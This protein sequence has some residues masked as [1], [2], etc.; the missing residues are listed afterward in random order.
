MNKKRSA[1]S[2]RPPKEI[3]NDVP[4]VVHSSTPHKLVTRNSRE[5]RQEIA[6]IFPKVNELLTS[7][8]QTETRDKSTR[9]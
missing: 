5:M 4:K 2:T 8:Y 3:T 7:W 9:L 6:W 1:V